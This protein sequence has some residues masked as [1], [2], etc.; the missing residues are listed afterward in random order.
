MKHDVVLLGDRVS[1][2][3]FARVEV[4]TEF[5]LCECLC[6]VLEL[7]TADPLPQT[8]FRAERTNLI[9]VESQH[10]AMGR[11]FHAAAHHFGLPGQKTQTAVH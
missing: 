6:T 11:Q 2:Q 4:V 3:P 10:D 8:V 7:R 1:T 9:V 5:I